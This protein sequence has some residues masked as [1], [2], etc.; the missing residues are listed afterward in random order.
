MDFFGRLAGVLAQ[1]L[2]GRNAAEAERY[3]RAQAAAE[4]Q[5]QQRELDAQLKTRALQDS[6]LQFQIAQQPV[7]AQRDAERFGWDQ[8][9]RNF[10]VNELRPRQLRAQDLGLK[11]SELDLAGKKTGNALSELT[12]RDYESPQQKRARDN[13]AALSL[14]GAK[15]DSRDGGS[16]QP[17]AVRERINKLQGAVDNIDLAIG[18]MV[19]PKTKQI[20]DV[21]K[22]A[23]GDAQTWR[24]AVPAM[25]V[26]GNALSPFV[27][28]RMDRS[29]SDAAVAM[30][31]QVASA[32]SML[33]NLLSGAAIS[34]A[35]YV[36][37]KG[38]VP[39]INESDPGTALAKLRNL[40]RELSQSKERYA[41]G[42]SPQL[43][44][45]ADEFAAKLME[46]GAGAEE[47]RQAV[48]AVYGEA[49]AGS[50]GRPPWGW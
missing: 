19:D 3:R 7:A 27:N 48:R 34:P 42:G 5:R 44:L 46:G 35:E 1:G 37:L 41:G 22:Q 16:T 38:F 24:N 15:A 26:V 40:R 31:A 10:T 12:L 50:A 49:A 25:P 2:A 18:G 4:E 33:L 32:G 20:T 47:V 13:A 36:R 9:D 43:D 8:Q 29:L 28:R 6:L 11:A 45:S 30:R 17:V 14:L 23:F 21:A 39:D